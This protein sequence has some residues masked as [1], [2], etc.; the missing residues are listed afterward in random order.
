M[1]RKAI[2]DIEQAVDD[3]SQNYAAAAGRRIEAERRLGN[4]TTHIIKL[5]EKARLA[6][7][8][9]RDDLASAIIT[10]QIAYEKERADWGIAL[11]KANDETEK[12]R[13]DVAAMKMRK[14]DLQEQLLR[15]V[16]AEQQVAIDAAADLDRDILDQRVAGAIAAYDEAITPASLT[17]DE[18]LTADQ[19]MMVNDEVQARM[20]MLRQEAGGTVPTA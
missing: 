12:L 1:L 19:P 11:A 17:A 9:K 2:R 4:L 20:D 8:Q 5:D 15:D 18:G 10:Q 6:I 3:L 16:Q 14:V 13:A 7:S